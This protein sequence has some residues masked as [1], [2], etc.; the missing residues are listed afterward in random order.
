MTISHTE[1]SRLDRKRLSVGGGRRALAAVNYRCF[2]NY[3]H[4]L[5]YLQ[6]L[7]SYISNVRSSVNHWQLRDLL[8]IDQS[9]GAVYHTYEDAIR[10]LSL[11]P[12]GETLM[13]S[14]DYLRLP[15]FPRCFNQAL[16]GVVVAGGVVMSLSKVYQMNISDLTRRMNGHSHTRPLKGLFSLYTPEMDSEMTFKLGEM[17]NNAVTIYPKN[18]TAS[19]PDFGPES[20]L[21]S[22]SAYT[23]YVCN[24]DSSLYIVDVSNNAVTATRSVVCETNTSL[25]NVHQAPDGRL[26]TVTGDSGNIFLMDPRAE[27]ATIDTIETPHDSGFGISYHNNENVLASAFQDGNCSLFDLRRREAPLREIRSTRPG[28]NSGA[29]RCCKFLRSP[30]Q[31]LLVILEHVGRVHLIDLR[32][33]GEEN[34]Q[35]IVF[36]FAL[37]QFG[38]YKHDRLS[39][40]EKLLRSQKGFDF[41][42][43]DEDAPADIDRIDNHKRFEVFNESSAYFSAPLVYD[44]DYLVDKNPKL[45][46][47]YEY[48]APQLPIC[49]EDDFLGNRPQLNLPQWN[50]APVSVNSD[51]VNTWF[52][53]DDNGY[54][55]VAPSIDPHDVRERLDLE[56]PEPSQSE[57]SPSDPRPYHPRFCHDS[58]QQSVNH[59]HGEMGLSGIDWFENQLYIGCVDG[60]ILSWDINVKARRSFGSFSYV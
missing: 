55:S 11:R 23:S 18:G 28:H 57:L 42:E 4:A 25:N 41:A 46:K 9:S 51:C 19:S 22:S 35:V 21:P 43:E 2:Q 14:H 36:P 24:N 17:I 38:H 34:H 39:I 56:A 32:D 52:D 53:P 37:D 16:G 48:H 59:T 60:G 13:K 7:P 33:L 54:S 27:K 6:P 50:S 44:Y 40:R 58:Y 31:D 20:A 8:Q 47:D 12:R 30:I 10:V 26:L 1:M 29:F 5:K 49:E 3:Y 45:F 15:Y